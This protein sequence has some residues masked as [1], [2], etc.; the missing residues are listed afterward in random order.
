[1]KIKFMK[2]INIFSDLIRFKRIVK[3]KANNIDLKTM[4]YTTQCENY[5]DGKKYNYCKKHIKLMKLFCEKYHF[6][7]K[8]YSDINISLLA[9]IELNMRH[10]YK[11]RFNLITDIKHQKW[12]KHLQFLS[13][14]IE[15]PVYSTIRNL[16]NIILHENID[17]DFLDFDYEY[18]LFISE[19]LLNNKKKYYIQNTCTET[20]LSKYKINLEYFLNNQF[21]DH[22]CS[23][24]LNIEMLNNVHK[25]F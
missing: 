12:L 11:E 17:Y 22:K 8:N 13:N 15:Y 3:C 23:E 21:Y 2:W 6:I 16:Y 1:M 14:T 20:K 10:Q 4:K 18:H 7:D 25:M 9:K 19:K 24:W 5:C